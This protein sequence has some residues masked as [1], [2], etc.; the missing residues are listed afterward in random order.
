LRPL[1]WAG[2]HP[3]AGVL[4]PDESVAGVANDPEITV[5]VAE[6]RKITLGIDAALKIQAQPGFALDALGP[7]DAL[8]AR[9]ALWSSSAVRTRRASGASRAIITGWSP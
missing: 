6:E 8:L 5:R 1:D 3:L 2:I 7:L 9:H 4:I